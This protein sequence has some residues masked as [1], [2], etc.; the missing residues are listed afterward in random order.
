LTKA[1]ERRP[2]LSGMDRGKKVCDLVFGGYLYE[3]IKLPL[4]RS[5]G[6]VCLR[7]EGQD[8]SG[9]I[10]TNRRI[11]GDINKATEKLGR[12]PDLPAAKVIAGQ[13]FTNFETD[14]RPMPRKK[15]KLTRNTVRVGG[16]DR[17]MGVSRTIRGPIKF[18]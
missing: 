9:S 6:G 15:K 8:S 11:P 12:G 18:L 1:T 14:Q 4:L 7:R 16:M 13:E 17:K 3:E 2:P 10:C 5:R